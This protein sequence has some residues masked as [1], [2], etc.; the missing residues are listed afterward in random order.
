MPADAPVADLEQVHLPPAQRPAGGRDAEELA[1]V[2]PGDRR[3]RG[4]PRPV[5]GDWLIPGRQA[6]ERVEGRPAV[7]AELGHAGTVGAGTVIPV[8]RRECCLDIGVGGIAAPQHL[9]GAERGQM[10]W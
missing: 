3:V 10:F 6:T 2:H 5:A 8:A 1:A 9:V 7:R 4:K